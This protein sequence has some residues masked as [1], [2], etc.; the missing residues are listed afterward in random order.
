MQKK[1]FRYERKYYLTPDNAAIF[2]HRVSCLLQADKHS[3]GSYL[4]SSLYFDDI[5]GTALHEKQSGV[6]T[7]DKWRVRWY[8]NRFDPVHLERKHKEGELGLKLH[9][10][11]S[12]EQYRRLCAGT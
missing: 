12:E 3:K 6:F 11:I 1:Q 10:K 4:I 2:R 5:Y 8:N 9:D 7:R